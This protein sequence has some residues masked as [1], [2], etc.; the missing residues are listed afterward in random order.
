MQHATITHGE[1]VVIQGSLPNAAT[2]VLKRA[3]AFQGEK[4]WCC[5]PEAWPRIEKLLR[6]LGVPL[7]VEGMPMAP[8]APVVVPDLRRKVAYVSYTNRLRI[9]GDMPKPVQKHWL[10]SERHDGHVG[11]SPW[12]LEEFIAD[13]QAQ[14]IEVELDP[15]ATALREK[16]N[17]RR[18]AID[19]ILDSEDVESFP[20]VPLKT[21]TLSNEQRRALAFI[22]ACGGRAFIADSVGGQKTTTAIGWKILAKHQRILIIARSSVKGNWGKELPK[23][24]G[25]PYLILDGY[26]TGREPLPHPSVRWLIT[27]YDTV[28]DREVQRK[29]KPTVTYPGWLEYLTAWKPTLVIVDE[30]HNARGDGASERSQGMQ[31]IAHAIPNALLLTA[32]PQS[33]GPMDRWAQLDALE[34]GWWGTWFEYGLAFC[35][36]KEKERF[37]GRKRWKY[38]DMSGKSNLD[39]LNRRMRYVVLARDRQTLGTAIPS[40]RFLMQMELP[41]EARKKY[42]AVLAEYRAHLNGEKTDEDGKRSSMLHLSKNMKYILEMRKIS[43]H[44]RPPST[45][46]LVDGMLREGRKVVVFAYFVP[47]LEAIRDGLRA[48]GWQVGYIRG[49]VSREARD[50]IQ[51]EF[52]NGNLDVVVGQ[53][54]ATGE[55]VNFQKPSYTTVTH[56][57]T[58]RPL[59]V[60]QTEGRVNRPGQPAPETEHIYCI[61]ART[62]DEKTLR[63]LLEKIAANEAL[64]RGIEDELRR[65]IEA[66]FFASPAESQ[67]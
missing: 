52:E 48:K 51:T 15:A 64:E 42:D 13:C 23:F 10:G 16:L 29:G 2:S 22:Q 35:N 5:L 34:P 11:M 17:Q 21:S 54:D 8:T 53:T 49:G 6:G 4:G 37:A 46:E 3:G 28:F 25:D 1:L 50:A 18:Q 58:Y 19:R 26:R 47:S 63:I 66:E 39:V 57:L 12:A 62:Y 36:G 20:N 32:T 44:S 41:P 9:Q 65:E 55:G 30:S 60:T 14:R 27:S 31:A 45:V 7:V 67:D 38:W 24:D 56:D 40:K 43:S 33:N 59:D 61:G